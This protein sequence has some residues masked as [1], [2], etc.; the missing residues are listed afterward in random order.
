M[1]KLEV[2]KPFKDMWLPRYKLE[3]KYNHDIYQFINISGRVA[4]KTMNF[5]M[6]M[7]YYSFEY[8]NHDIVILRANSSQLK[9]SVFKAF[10]KYCAEHLPYDI[11]SRIKFRNSPPLEITM[12]MGNQIYF[13]GVGMGSKSGSNQSRGKET[14]RKVSL[15]IVEETQEIFSGSSD[16]EELLKQ[17]IATYMRFLDD[18]IGF[19]IYA[20]N[21][22]R[23]VNA[24]FN[25]WVK[26]KEKDKYFLI[27]ESS[28]F[29]IYKHLNQATI[30][31]IEQEKELN[32]NNYKYMYLGIPIGGDDLV[33]GAFTE[34]VHV[35]PKKFNLKKELNKTGVDYGIYQ[36]YIGVD[37]AVTQD[38]CVFMPI[39]H[40]TNAKLVLS[41]KDILYHDPQKNGIVTNNIMA[42]K[43]A[44]EWLKNLVG[45]YNL[46]HKKITFV[47]DGHNADL[48]E[49]LTYELAPFGNVVVIK[50]TKK[51]LVDTSNKVNNA[52]TEKLLYLTNESWTEIISNDEIHPSILFNE[53][54]TVCWREDD[55]TKFN[56]IIPNDMTDGIRYPIAYHTT[57]PY[58]MRNLTQKGGN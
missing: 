3:K 9:Q 1:N 41:C 20:G 55:R 6:L 28:Y 11:Y 18:E 51:D 56:D 4:G 2:A 7:F 50:F 43:Y 57:T 49:N 36:L 17:S 58:Q 54:Q 24:K 42:K 22:E 39:F 32:P 37:G 34:S 45:E 40:L 53:L 14:D 33:Y 25:L 10:K 46:F 15:I 29:D 19:V 31:M 12:P 8:Q 30:R 48:I 52:F 26:K 23:N 16:G 27:I 35:L 5:I 44:K 38:K 21:R 13:G 47:V